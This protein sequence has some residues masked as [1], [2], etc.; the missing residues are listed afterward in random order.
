M[1]DLCVRLLMKETLINNFKALELALLLIRLIL[2]AELLK[3]VTNG[4]NYPQ[5]LLPPHV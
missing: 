1:G 5:I 2:S 4:G 3:L